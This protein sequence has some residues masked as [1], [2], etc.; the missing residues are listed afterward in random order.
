MVNLV[1][2][3]DLVV[4]AVLVFHF[5]YI[6]RAVKNYTALVFILVFRNFNRRCTFPWFFVWETFILLCNIRLFRYQFAQCSSIIPE[7]IFHQI[8]EGVNVVF[9]I[10]TSYPCSWNTDRLRPSKILINY[11]TTHF[12][13]WLQSA[14]PNKK[15][16]KLVER[17]QAVKI[18]CK[19][20]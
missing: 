5:V 13:N 14:M 7:P 15:V 4:I 17:L 1:I 9:T 19:R 3:E 16:S 18:R 20:K 12:H 2:Q 8:C 11:T 6:M 10:G